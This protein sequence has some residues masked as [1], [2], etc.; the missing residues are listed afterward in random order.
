MIDTPFTSPDGEPLTQG[1]D[2]KNVEN[3]EN[4]Q[5]NINELEE[6]ACTL[7]EL[8]GNNGNKKTNRE[9]P[10]DG[11]SRMNAKRPCVRCELYSLADGLKEKARE[12]DVDENDLRDVCTYLTEKVGDCKQTTG[13]FVKSKHEARE[14]TPRT[15]DSEAQKES[16]NAR[17][18][19]PKKKF[20]SKIFCLSKVS[21]GTF[22]CILDFCTRTFCH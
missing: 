1:V 4:E 18:K 19:S 16:E 21:E 2:E 8:N 3:D 5:P 9:K 20:L 7:H 11:I 6:A 22:S 10:C 14:S 17:T 13:V 15:Q 12:E